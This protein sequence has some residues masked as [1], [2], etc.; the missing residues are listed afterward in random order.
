MGDNKCPGHNSF[1]E[2]NLAANIVDRKTYE[3]DDLFA[4]QT[5]QMIVPN[6][7]VWRNLP[8]SILE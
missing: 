5:V 3:P 4:P 1:T 7:L 6:S 8:L 2:T